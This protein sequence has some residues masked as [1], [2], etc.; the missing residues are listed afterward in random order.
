MGGQEP[1]AELRKNKNG[2]QVP[3]DS[4]VSE[5]PQSKTERSKRP[6]AAVTT[7]ITLKTVLRALLR[8]IEELV[9]RVWHLRQR[10]YFICDFVLLC[11]IVRAATILTPWHHAVNSSAAAA[12]HQQW[13]ILY[14]LPL[15]MTLGLQTLN[16]QRELAGLSFGEI[17]VRVAIGIGLGMIAFIMIFYGATFQ[18]VGRYIMLYSF[19]CGTAVATLFRM[20]LWTT[21]TV[22]IWRIVYI[23]RFDGFCNLQRMVK[24][25]RMPIR[26]AMLPDEDLRSFAE[27]CVKHGIHEVVVGD[28]HEL[29]FALD[30]AVAQCAVHQ[31]RVSKQESFVERTFERLYIPEAGEG[32]VWLD[33]QLDRKATYLR[34]KRWCEIGFS[35]AVLLLVSVPLVLTLVF[36]RLLD[37]GPGLYR[38]TRVGRGGIPFSMCKLRTMHVDAERD[39]PRW[40]DINDRRTTRIGRI[41]RRTRIDELPQLWNVV[42]GDMALIG[43]RPERPEMIGELEATTCVYAYRHS[44][45]PGITGWAQVNMDYTASIL[46][47]RRKL[48]LDLYYIKRMSPMLDLIIIVRTVAAML[49]G[50]R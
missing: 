49:R 40:A 18:L 20:V 36:I 10:T 37:G 4:Q 2:L 11:A 14:G 3:L 50:A 45:L 35:L 48:E 30:D 21:A 25:Q 6:E 31:L 33:L 15:M 9:G 22:D 13:L 32:S 23:G 41:L 46:E 24:E 19:V 28:V 1:Q 7:G 42:R 26:I 39:G 44:V 16:I 27:Y 34:I 5:S 12:G 8:L 47:S 38:Q 43:P 29:S 17:A